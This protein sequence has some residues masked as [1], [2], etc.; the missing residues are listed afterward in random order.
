MEIRMSMSFLMSVNKG[1][2]TS[3][4]MNVR[5]CLCL[6]IYFASQTASLDIKLATLAASLRS[7]YQQQELMSSHVKLHIHRKKD[8]AM[9]FPFYVTQ[10]I[11]VA[12][13]SN[14]LVMQW[15]VLQIIFVAFVCYFQATSIKKIFEKPIKSIWSQKRKLLRVFARLLLF[16]FRLFWF[17][18]Y[19]QS[20]RHLL[21]D[22][23]LRAQ[24][25]GDYQN[26]ICFRHFLPGCFMECWVE[27][28]KCPVQFKT[29]SSMLI[30]QEGLWLM[31]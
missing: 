29:F 10:C 1:N 8:N 20:K 27:H 15:H 2:P 17:F 16:T 12:L 22:D 3:H 14:G 23:G 28:W 19:Q 25:A 11:L 26:T 21:H 5:K 18:A 6:F 7:V 24:A 13:K 9:F 30:W 4:R 31:S